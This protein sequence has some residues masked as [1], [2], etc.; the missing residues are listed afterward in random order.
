MHTAVTFA[1]LGLGAGGVYGLLG[2]GLVLI[3]RG[4]GLVNFAHGAMAMSAAY[5]F[6][7]FTQ[8]GLGNALSFV[9][10][11][12][13]LGVVGLVTQVGVM[14]RLRNASGL[15]R[16]IATVGILAVLD[17][18]FSKW[19]GATTNTIVP[20]ILPTGSFHLGS[21]TFS[22][23]AVGL[24][25]VAIVITAALTVWSKRSASGMA[26][27]AV[28]ESPEAASALGWSPQI[29][30]TATWIG[31]AVL[32]AV[33]GILIAPSTGLVV[34]NM[35]LIVVAALAAAILGG[36]ESFPIVFL[37]GLVIGIGQSEMAKYITAP[38]WSDTLPF[39]IVIAWLVVRGRGLPVRSHVMERLPSLGSGVI[40][41]RS[42]V[43]VTIA[44]I[45]CMSTFFSQD[46]TIAIN[47]QVAIAVILLSIVVVTG[48]AG[49]LSLAQYGLAG[50]GAWVSGRL[51][52]AQHWPFLFALLAGIA[53]AALVGAVLGAPA[54][55]TRGVNLAIVTLGLGVALQDL[56]F[57]N[58]SYTGGIQGTTVNPPTLLGYSI[59]PIT[60]PTRYAAFSVVCLVIAAIVVGNVRRSRV[61][62]R[63][64]AV[65]ANERAAASLGVS[66]TGAKL[67]AFSLGAGIAGLGGT[68]LA[69]MNP[70][71]E[72]YSYDA[73]S[74]VN[75][76]GFGTIGG[77]A[78][79]TGPL[80]G[81]G[82]QNGGV[83]SIVLN[84]IGGLD[85]WLPLIGGVVILLVLIQNPGGM[86]GAK[87]PRL[88]RRLVDLIVW[89]GRP[90]VAVVGAHAPV[91]QRTA[92]AP[93]VTARTLRAPLA[94]LSAARAVS[95]TVPEREPTAPRRGD[96][97]SVK[98]LTVRFGGVVAVNNVSLDV[99][100]GEIVGLIGPNGAGKTTLIDAVTGFVAAAGGQITLGDVNLRKLPPY[101]RSRAGVVRTFQSLELLEDFT[102]WDNFRVAIEPRDG[103][104]YL[105]SLFTP[106]RQHSSAS[107]EAAIE[108]FK[109][110]D[111]LGTFPRDLPYGTRRLLGIARAVACDPNTLL[112][113]EPAS[114]LDHS[115]RAELASLIRS[116]A[117]ERG[118]GVLLVEHDMELV[119]A[120][121][122]RVVVLEFGSVIGTGTPAEVR[123]NPAVISA[124]LGLSQDVEEDAPAAV[125]GTE[126]TTGGRHA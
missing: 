65:R 107:A 87:Q 108:S 119:M 48:F 16:L 30:A 62:R 94:K 14:R 106:G 96:R 2:S 31:G 52:A 35:T 69:F 32:A 37:A 12:A 99:A 117:Q 75:F 50:V 53:G 54:L 4:S 29:V 26:M 86:A 111:H 112:L 124:Y 84:S 93:E 40:P 18:L 51:A 123:A 1:V 66:V 19:F 72:Y 58:P 114:G 59:D 28:A 6:Y 42:V 13:I 125:D 60:T 7:E 64:I 74:S 43:P 25:V 36:F 49:Q 21:Y 95:R 126:T 92:S 76:V 101:R 11:V 56:V 100:P 34:T 41:L 88:I 61:G 122:D 103:L 70:S 22:T 97:L 17:G 44:L 120:V 45:V 90:P 33:A 85:S 121:C 110:A 105:T 109:L 83:G 80:Y 104:G 102:A 98:D 89:F 116:M 81:S 8:K 78:H 115:D 20:A 46:L 113:D 39:L 79:V 5:L 63:M 23:Q 91:D 71:I 38:G 47:V 77:I 68:L 57:L 9:L 3:Y 73:V 10:A 15:S 27:L 24:L 118:M 55:R 67:Y 82:F